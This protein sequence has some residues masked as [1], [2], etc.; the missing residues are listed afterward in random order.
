MENEANFSDLPAACLEGLSV[1]DSYPGEE[2]IF[3][4]CGYQV[5]IRHEQLTGALL[6]ISFEERSM[7]LP[8]F[9]RLC[10]NALKFHK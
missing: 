10:Y 1:P 8:F 7:P 9:T 5:P 2:Y 3:H 6:D 4:V